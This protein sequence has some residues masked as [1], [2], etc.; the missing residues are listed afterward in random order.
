MSLLESSN[1]GSRLPGDFTDL[2]GS[3]LAEAK[4]STLGIL[5]QRA[6]LDY[7]SSHLILPHQTWEHHE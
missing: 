7:G 5:A 2:D 6:Q 1:A 3:P 4:R